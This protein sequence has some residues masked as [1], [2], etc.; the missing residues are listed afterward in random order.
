[1]THMISAEK[2]L[3]TRGAD[4]QAAQRRLQCLPGLNHWW[5]GPDFSQHV[6]MTI[7]NQERRVCVNQFQHLMTDLL[8]WTQ[9]TYICTDSD[10]KRKCDMSTSQT[11]CML[12]PPFIHRIMTSYYTC[13]IVS[14]PAFVRK[15]SDMVLLFSSP[16]LPSWN[17]FS[18]VSIETEHV[19]AHSSALQSQFEGVKLITLMN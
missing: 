15:I 16:G 3:F 13:N 11:V 7:I 19:S 2:S 5:Q 18:T 8:S 10:V 12:L 9:K 14:K 17:L 4:E 6:I 1:M